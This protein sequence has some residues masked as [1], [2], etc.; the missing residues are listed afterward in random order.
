MNVE[1]GSNFF[2]EAMLFSWYAACVFMVLNVIMMI[3]TFVLR[4]KYLKEYGW[5]Y[6]TALLGLGAFAVTLFYAFIS[7]LRILH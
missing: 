2:G 3:G 7:L 1:Y 6:I 5:Y 4:I